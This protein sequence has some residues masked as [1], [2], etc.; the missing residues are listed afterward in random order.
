M[1][2]DDRPG[3]RRWKSSTATMTALRSTSISNPMV[4]RIIVFTNSALPAAQPATP[5]ASIPRKQSILSNA[6]NVSFGKDSKPVMMDKLRSWTE[7]EATR[8]FSGVAVYEKRFTVPADMLKEG[9]AV[10]LSFG[11]SPNPRLKTDGDESECRPILPNHPDR[12]PT[13]PRPCGPRPGPARECRRSSMP[14]S[15]RRRWFT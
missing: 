5:A 11:G 12:R 15:A 7:N 10:Q 14:R 8:Y 2:S 3:F 13:P 4:L 1:G 9:L 6:W